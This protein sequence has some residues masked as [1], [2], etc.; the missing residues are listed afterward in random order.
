MKK[1]LIITHSKDN[2]CVETVA[3]AI[4]K[5]GGEAIRFD[6]DLY[7]ADS[8]LTSNFINGKEEIWYEKDGQTYPLHEC[9]SLWFRRFYDVGRTLIPQL[10]EE[11]LPAALEESKRT[12]SGMMEGFSGFR[13]GTTSQYRRLDSREEQIKLAA[14]VGITVPDTCISNSSEQVKEFI[15]SHPQG[16][17][18]KMQSS[19]AVYREG[20]EHVVFTNKITEEDLGDLDSL[21]YTPMMFQEQIQ[22]Q[23]E[24]RITIIGKKIFSHA[25]DSQKS[26]RAQ[27]DWRKDGAAMVK[28]WVAYPLPADLEVKLQQFMDIY[29]AN[30]G[31]ID[32]ILSPDGQYYFLEINAAGEFFWLDVLCDYEMSAHFA[33]VLLDK[34]PRR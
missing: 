23:L 20:V 8:R 13:L 11:Y 28:D 17:I 4:A 32:F 12:L 3:A 10:E 24:L 22:K 27:V 5:E 18:A 7:P 2:S 34:A 1:V 30:Y 29:G 16:V 9:T 26:E 31:A 33:K 15:R 6:V 19:F 14:S 21:A 25:I